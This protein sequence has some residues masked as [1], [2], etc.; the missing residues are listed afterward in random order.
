M[1]ARSK[2][3]FT[4]INYI[5]M[6]IGLGILVIGFFIMT[7]DKE[8][9]GFGFLGLTLGPIIVMIGFLT[10]FIAIFYKDKKKQEDSGSKNK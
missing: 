10:Q 7:Q 3:A 5:I 1:E 8:T 4:R 6:L 9:F 2:F